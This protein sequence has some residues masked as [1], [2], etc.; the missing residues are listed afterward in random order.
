MRLEIP[1]NEKT[2]SNGDLLTIRQTLLLN[3]KLQCG[4]DILY[5]VLSV[6]FLYFF[7]LRLKTVSTDR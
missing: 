4:G 2:K 5:N 6:K 3:D 7:K 1:R